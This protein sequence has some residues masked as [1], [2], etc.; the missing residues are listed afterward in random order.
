MLRK[1]A[2]FL[3]KVQLNMTTKI[4]TLFVSIVIASSSNALVPRFRRDGRS[5]RQCSKALKVDNI[6]ETS[7]SEQKMQ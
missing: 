7:E 5:P 3:L 2:V 1:E 4:I 6:F